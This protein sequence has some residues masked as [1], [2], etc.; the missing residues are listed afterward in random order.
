MRPHYTTISDDPLL[1]TFGLSY[2]LVEAVKMIF[3]SD[4]IPFPP[5][6]LTGVVDLGVGYYPIYRLFVVGW[7]SP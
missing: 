2:V 4:G 5:G 1:L 3:G 6:E 7:S